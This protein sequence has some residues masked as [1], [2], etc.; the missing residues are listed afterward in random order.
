MLAGISKHAREAT[1]FE[2]TLGDI[3]QATREARMQRAELERMQ[4]ANVKQ[5]GSRTTDAK[6]GP[7]VNAAGLQRV[8]QAFT[9]AVNRVKSL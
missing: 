1:R 8:K 6:Y 5:I 3:I 2:P 4:R 9:D 7:E